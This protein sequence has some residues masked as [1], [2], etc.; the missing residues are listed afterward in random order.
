[1]PLCASLFTSLLLVQAAPPTVAEATSD[2]ADGRLTISA[3]ASEPMRRDDVRSKLAPEGLVLYLQDVLIPRPQTFAATAGRA[4]N[5]LPRHDYTKLV[6]PLPDLRCSGPIEI[7]VSE[8]RVRASVGCTPRAQSA[9]AAAVAPG[10]G[11]PDRKAWRPLPTAPPAALPAAA[12]TVVAPPTPAA[13]R[14]AAPVAAAAASA[15]P[16]SQTAPASSP[17]TAPA[18]A[19]APAVVAPP[20]PARTGSAADARPGPRTASAAGGIGSA[21]ALTVGGLALGASFFLLWRRR[22]RHGGSLIRI[23]ESASLGPR[24]AL[25]VAE[26]DGQKMVLGTSEAGIALLTPLTNGTGIAIA[27]LRPPTGDDPILV[28]EETPAPPVG[29]EK[30][31]LSRL[32]SRRRE[33]PFFPE[34]EGPSTMAEDFRDLLEDSLDDEELRRRLQAG[35]G[36]RTP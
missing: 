31:F 33:E 36:S 35:I 23:L 26:I 22:Q 34:E 30:G 10:R 2:F 20:A 7:E 9:A 32:F 8:T 28:T 5:A 17:P 25:V 16:P 14:P 27:E 13:A 4:V 29:G 3:V 24:R 21:W 15:P 6:V 1:M 19:A 18:V 12:P 11:S